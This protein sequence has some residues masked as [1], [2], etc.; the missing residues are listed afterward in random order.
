MTRKHRDYALT[1]NNQTVSQVLLRYLDLEGVH[2]VFG[3]PGGGIANLLTAFKDARDEFQYV[4]CRHETGAAY[5]ADGYHRVTGNL[6]VVMVTTGPGATNA[7]TGAMNAQAA[8]SA[9]LVMTGE[10]NEQYFGMGYLQ[11]G[12]GSGHDVQQIYGAATRS[13]A[14]VSDQ[15]NFQTLLTQALREAQSIPAAATHLSIP[16]NVAAETVTSVHVPASVANY[17]AVPM[18]APASQTEQAL[19]MLLAARRPL[20]LLGNGC[21]RALRGPTGERFQAFVER[22]GI[23]VI[24]TADGKGVFPEDH[25]LSLRV[26]GFASCMWPQYWMIPSRQDPGAPDHFDALLV[27][28]SSLDDLA[29]NKWDPMLLPDGPLIQVDLQ[30]S[31]IG[32]SLHVALGVVAEVGAFVDELARQSG[33]HPPDPAAVAAREAFVAAI[34]RDH[35]PVFDPAQYESE[36]SP[37]QPAALI[38]VL[39]DTLPGDA[40]IFLDAG[41]CVGWGNHCF[42]IAQPREIFSSLAMGPMGFA[43]GAVVGATF[44]A[45]G[46]TCV[47]VVGDGAFMMHGAE[48]STAAAHKKGAIWFVLNDDDLHMV[49][50]G[51]AH[52]FPDPTDPDVWAHLY[53]LGDPNLVW[54]ARGL[55]ADAVEVDSPAALRE[56][57]PDVLAGSRAGRPQV[58]IV[59]IDRAAAP[60]YYIA[61]YNSAPAEPPP[62][63]HPTRYQ[64]KIQ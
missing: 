42:E 50:Q 59:R 54:F 30:Q 9:M 41:N 3:I 61:A 13:S 18:G 57:M 8:G 22:Y 64:R 58:V 51:Q 39:Q 49:S 44:G 10:V 27:L 40:A 5:A 25:P 12:V 63:G 20:I 43:V 29:T 60:P 28:G 46:R 32:R 47:A 62:A 1:L 34:K 16:N 37:C 52:F 33:A 45:P 7:L 56:R 17:R 38:R 2:H 14:V 53:R 36:A 26:Y 4:V 21:R 35:S 19:K 31:A 55:G 24:T 11:E 48:V 15:S 6:G 23:P